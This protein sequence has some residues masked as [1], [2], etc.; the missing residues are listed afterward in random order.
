MLCDI[1]GV[2]S[3]ILGWISNIDNVKSAIMFI[4]GTIYIG[5]RTYFYIRRQ[6]ILI[7]KESWE[8]K[9]REAE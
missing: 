5:A 4:L 9:Q 1:L 3:A 7:R 8:Q 2:S 6:L